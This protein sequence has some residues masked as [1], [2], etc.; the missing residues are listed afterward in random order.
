MSIVECRDINKTYQQGKIEVHALKGV[1]L[2]IDKGGFVALAG[3]S[4]SGKT[5]RA[6][7]FT[8]GRICIPVL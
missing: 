8:Q 4:G 3:P 5:T 7:S 6:S 2:S 1:S